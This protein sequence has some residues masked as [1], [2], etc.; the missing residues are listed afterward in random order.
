MTVS[1]DPRTDY[2]VVVDGARQTNKAVSTPTALSTTTDY[3]LGGIQGSYSQVSDRYV[4]KIPAGSLVLGDKNRKLY[5]LKDIGDG[6][7]AMNPENDTYN[8]RGV[9]SHWIDITYQQLGSIEERVRKN[10]QFYSIM[11]QFVQNLANAKTIA[12]IR[13]V[14]NAAKL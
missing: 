4:K 12:E 14:A 10:E 5:Q 7:S 1:I 11:A 13:G 2:L 6:V 8:T 9:G 3:F